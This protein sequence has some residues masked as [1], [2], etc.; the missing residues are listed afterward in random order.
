MR[1]RWD[2]AR[3]SLRLIAVLPNCNS[4]IRNWI[5]AQASEDER[6]FTRN[7]TLAFH[8]REA[9]IDRLV[10]FKNDLD[11]VYRGAVRRVNCSADI[12]YVVVDVGSSVLCPDQ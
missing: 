5:V 3:N 4:V 12:K 10:H 6:S 9:V 11:V 1:I 2:F 7:E 8:G